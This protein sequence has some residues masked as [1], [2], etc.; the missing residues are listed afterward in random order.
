M[1]GENWKRWEF[2][3]FNKKLERSS[4]CDTTSKL[5]IVNFQ[6]TTD[7]IPQ[8]RLFWCPL[9]FLLNYLNKKQSGNFHLIVETDEYYVSITHGHI[10][11]KDFF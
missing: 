6:L 5:C 8:I 1:L 2:S 4:T 7:C 10:R 11:F 9:Q 3:V